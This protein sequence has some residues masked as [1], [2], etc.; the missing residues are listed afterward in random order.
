MLCIRAHLDAV[1]QQLHHADVAP[2]RKEKFTLFSNHDGRILKRQHGSDAPAVRKSHQTQGAQFWEETHKTSTKWRRCPAASS[3]WCRPCQYTSQA[4]L[5]MHGF[6]QSF[7]KMRMHGM[8]LKLHNTR[9]AADMRRPVGKLQQ[10]QSGADSSSK[11]SK[12]ITLSPHR[13]KRL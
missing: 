4:K 2:V 9:K 13:S 8:R 5:R 12:A 3:C 11:W 7:N 10:D 6:C 1:Q